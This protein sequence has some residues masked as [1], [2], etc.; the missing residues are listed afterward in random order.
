VTKNDIPYIEKREINTC[1]YL[2]YVVGP[3]VMHVG[4]WAPF[5]FLSTT[6]L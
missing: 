5:R 3:K 4:L 1:P 6:G 2:D